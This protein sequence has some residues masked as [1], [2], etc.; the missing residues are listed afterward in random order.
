MKDKDLIARIRSGGQQYLGQVYEQ[1]RTEFIRWV[2]R[3][4]RCSDD[5][6]KDI[7]QVTILVFMENIQSGKLETLACSIKT[8][9]FGIGKNIAHENQRRLNRNVSLDM[10]ECLKDHFS[11]RFMEQTNELEFEAA[12]RAIAR[13]PESARTMIRLFYYERKSMSEIS[14][15]LN[16]K[17]PETAKNQKCKIMNRLRELYHAELGEMELAQCVGGVEMFRS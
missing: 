8:Y 4:F 2:T 10:E 16:Y 3:E 13:L 7:Y 1:Y 6:A 11:D 17:N 5:D 15:I 12:K 14:A 9:L